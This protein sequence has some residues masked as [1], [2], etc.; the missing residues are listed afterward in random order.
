MRVTKDY[1]DHCG[2]V[3]NCMKDYGDTEVTILTFFQTDL[4]ADCIKELDDIALK[5]CGKKGGAE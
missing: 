3:L 2:K 1:C 5:F 4:C